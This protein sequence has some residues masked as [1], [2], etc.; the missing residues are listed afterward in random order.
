[1]KRKISAVIITFNEEANIRRCLHSLRDIADEIVVVDSFSTDRTESI[2]SEFGVRFIKN[3]FVGHIEQKNFAMD[4][5]AHDLVLSLD[6]DEELSAE[7]QQSIAL[8]KANLS[9]KDRPEPDGYA[10]NR[11]NFYC[12]KFIRHG[13][14][15]PDRKIRLWNR[16]KGRWGGENPH[17]TVMMA[18]DSHVAKLR[19]DLLHYSYHT[20]ADHVAQMN[21]FSDIAA[22]EAF[23]KGKKTRLLIHLVFYPVYTFIKS[24]FLRLGL[25]DGYPGFLV[26]S[27]AAYYRFLKYSKLKNLWKQS[28]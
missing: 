15:Y 26:A 1:M 5:A 2:C 13:V 14:W 8:V 25:L 24:Y 20:L 12:G 27:Q 9:I 10:F 17:D 22:R 3:P 28:A 4:Q 11:L 16:R 23:K 18:K 19:G 6:A 21:K 7:L